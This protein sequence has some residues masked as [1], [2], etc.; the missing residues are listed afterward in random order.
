MDENQQGMA[1][2]MA[3]MV[4]VDGVYGVYTWDYHRLSLVKNYHA[5]IIHHDYH[6]LHMRLSYSNVRD[7]QFDGH[8]S[9][10]GW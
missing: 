8:I 7:V 2:G 1:N 5:R 10:D 6:S 9:H 3:I 4:D